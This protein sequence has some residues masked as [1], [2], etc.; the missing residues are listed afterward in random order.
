MR[1]VSKK[2]TDIRAAEVDTTIIRAD[3][4]GRNHAVVNINIVPRMAQVLEDSGPNM[5][6]SSPRRPHGVYQP[7]PRGEDGTYL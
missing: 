2:D 4:V 6:G 5:T 3:D 7:V 1:L